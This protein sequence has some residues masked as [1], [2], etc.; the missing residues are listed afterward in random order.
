MRMYSVWCLVKYTARIQGSD[1]VFAST[2]DEGIEFVLREGH[3]LPTQALSLIGC[4]L[5]HL[6]K[7]IGVAVAEMKEGEEAT[8]KLSSQCM[9]HLSLVFDA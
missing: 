1:V 5:G 4:V 6:C 2:P 7:G 9:R 8:V 3:T